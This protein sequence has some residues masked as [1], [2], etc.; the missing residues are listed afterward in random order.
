[1]RRRHF[2]YLLGSTAGCAATSSLT[3]G[4]GGGCS[5]PRGFALPIDMNGPHIIL[6]G[7]QSNEAEKKMRPSR[8]DHLAI[9]FDLPWGSPIFVPACGWAKAS[10]E[11]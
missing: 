11:V 5:S 9:D 4:S 1:M 2:L 3:S 7:W 6:Q 10:Y 8:P